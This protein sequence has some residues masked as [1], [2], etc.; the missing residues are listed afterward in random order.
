MKREGSGGARS[1]RTLCHRTGFKLF[2]TRNRMLLMAL[3]GPVTTLDMY[4][5]KDYFGCNVEDD[6]REIRVIAGDQLG[7]CYFN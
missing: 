4:F 1:S 3:T 5:S 2:L 6:W 7:S